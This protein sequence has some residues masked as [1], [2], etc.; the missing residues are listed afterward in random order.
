MS[1]RE[2][3]PFASLLLRYRAA[4]HLTQ[5]QLAARAGL[6]PDTIA[7]L[8]RGKRRMPR[9]ATVELL[10]QALELEAQ[11]RAHL[12][13]AAQAS[14]VRPRVRS[15]AVGADGSSVRDAHRRPWWLAM[16]PTPLVGRA[17]E[18]DTIIQTLAAEG[19]RLLTLTGP[20][21]VG[22]TR[23]ALAAAAQLAKDSEHFPDGVVLVD[24]TPVR[25]P[26][27]VLGAIARALGQLDV[28]GRTALE[29]L[30]EA[31]AERRQLVVLDNFEQVVEAAVSLAQVLATCPGL[32]LLVTSR[33]PLR[34][35][36]ERTLRVAPLPV[37]DLS[38]ALPPPTTLLAVPSVELFMERA[39]ARQV[40]LAFGE[41][42]AQLVAQ[43][44]AQLDG[45]PL[46]LELA[47]A[48]LDVLP[49]PTLAR[50]LGDHL[51]RM[52]A[53]GAPDAPER[54]QSL[55]A[56]V[57]WSYDLLSE[58]E[59]LVFRCLGV[60]VGR[61]TLDEITAVV[62]AVSPAGT[63][64]PEAGDGEVEQPGKGRETREAGRML[65]QLLSLADK[66]LVLPLSTRPEER[67]GKPL[68][69]PGQQWHDGEGL[70]DEAEEDEDREPA[71]GMLETVREYAWEQLAAA[72]ELTAAQRAHAHFFLALAERAAP[73]LRGRG[74]RAWYLR[75]EREH[76][77]LR[78]ALRWLLDEG[79]CD[80]R[81]GPDGLSA[82]AERE[83]GLRLAG[84]LGYFWY[85]RGYHTEGRRWLEKGL[86]LAPHR[87]G[88]T[89]TDSAARTRA[90]IASGP[91]LMVQAEYAPARE[92]LKEALAL[93]RQRQDPT[94][95]AEASTYLGHATVVGGNIE[96]GTQWLREAVRRWEALDDPHGLGEALFYLGYAADVMGDV[97]AA[98][99]HYTAALSGLGNAG[100]AQHAGFVHSYFGVVEWRRG[101]LLRAV[102]QIEAVL[103]TSVNLQDRWLLSF[104]AQATAVLV[105]SHAQTAGWARLLGAADALAQATGGATFGW[106]HL[107]GA[108]DAAGLREHLVRE[109]E[110]G[111]A[112]HEGWALPFGEV[113]AL[114]LRLLEEVATPASGAEAVSAAV[115]RTA[116]PRRESLL[117]ER[118]REVLRLVARGLSS[119]VIGREL[120][121]S[122]RTVAQHL[123]TIFNKLGASTRAQAVAVAA[124]RGLL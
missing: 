36:W 119:K 2:P 30:V 64:R 80:D 100:N 12:A 82:A 51:L 91:L 37:P 90:L 46:A 5:E 47:A 17:H 120:F 85:V 76:D 7:A 77:N 24:L 29:R 104:A 45:L 44:V 13:A 60:F 75:L 121:I 103:T 40:D 86:A 74:Q 114:A 22:K 65:P 98:E 28:G 71:F 108:H 94:A 1:T 88:G 81:N 27:L 58:P 62:G 49:L 118:E 72:G 67:R 59:R 21:G 109:G 124:Q 96:E 56:A 20:A 89:G 8:E 111:A 92:V 26:D 117:T 3:T 16:E 25:D 78:A 115:T 63:A 87:E 41:E 18:L 61:V 66:S 84:A 70:V 116:A 52:L 19:T 32:T 4:A 35:R 69:Q 48:R 39:W 11:E 68:G 99:A 73:N 79:D 83:A 34:L 123:T 15:A 53:S 50:R 31:L 105:G 6:S 38:L 113:A 57:G 122:E 42:Q 23:L 93:A 14:E 10:S 107:P 110:W 106:E 9:S 102:T 55:E 97:T 101:N 112:Y 95:I 43:L 54:Q 33:V